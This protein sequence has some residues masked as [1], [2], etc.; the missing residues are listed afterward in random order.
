VFEFLGERFEERPVR[1]LTHHRFNSSF[2]PPGG[3]RAADYRRPDP[4]ATWTDDERAVFADVCR[5]DMEAL[6]FA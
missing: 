2:V 6:G 4:L 5:A 1:F 3:C